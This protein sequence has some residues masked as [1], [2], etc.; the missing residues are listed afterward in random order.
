MAIPSSSPAP[1]LRARGRLVPGL[2]VFLVSGLACQAGGAAPLPFA[3]LPADAPSPPQE[4]AWVIFGADT[5]VAEIAATPPARERGLMFRE[6]VPD[7]TGMLFVFAEEEVRGFWMDNTYVDL[8]IAFLDA[9]YR[10]VDI[11]QMEA[12]D[13]EVREA[14]VPFMYALEVRRGWLAEKGIALG[15]EA[16]IEMGGPGGGQPT[17]PLARSTRPRAATSSSSL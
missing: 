7:G 17:V 5:V 8:D 4:H 10:I 6:S 2:V 3:V 14:R 15:D 16:R 11:Q 13:T 12:M 1:R 9:A